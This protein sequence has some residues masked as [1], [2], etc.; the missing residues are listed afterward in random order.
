MANG[1]GNGNGHSRSTRPSW[2]TRSYNFIDKDP[3][4]DRFRTLFQKERR[5]GL[6]RESDL[7]VLAG[8][9][10]QTVKNMFGGETRRPLHSTLAKIAGALGYEYGLSR[11]LTPNYETEIP[12]AK[13][14]RREYQAWLVKKRERAEKRTAR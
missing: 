6:R 3:E 10:P 2:S 4:V 8:V 7:A 5:A 14:E 11:K 1:N 9:S 13:E 12:K